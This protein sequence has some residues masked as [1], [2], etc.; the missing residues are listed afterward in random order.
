MECT[1]CI[2]CAL[3]WS[4]DVLIALPADYFH[5]LRPLSSIEVGGKKQKNKKIV[6]VVVVV[7]D[8]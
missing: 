1:S 3:Y 7:L 8:C 2:R 4:Y 6:V 5:K